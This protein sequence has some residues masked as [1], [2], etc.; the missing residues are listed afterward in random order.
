MFDYSLS[1]EHCHKKE[2]TWPRP[3]LTQQ[4]QPIN[5]PPTSIQCN[6]SN[7]DDHIQVIKDVSVSN[8]HHSV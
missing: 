7:K 8:G 4:Q 3:K 2:Q 1:P 6:T 5:K